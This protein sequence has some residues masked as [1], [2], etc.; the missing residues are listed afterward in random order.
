M[1]LRLTN[2]DD[3]CTEK[4]E[5]TLAD[6]NDQFK[7]PVDYEELLFVAEDDEGNFLGGL[8]AFRAWELLSIEMLASVSK[9][10]GTGSKLLHM[11]ED[12]CR[13]NG[14][15]KIKLWTMDF[16]A[17]LFYE[18]HGF[19]AFGYVSNLAGE[20]GATYMVKEVNE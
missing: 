16:Q 14:L 12:Y 6:Y 10:Q 13:Q 19:S 4:V 1:K 15:K 7:P 3:P 9:N 11:A 18:K 17:K 8:R 20:Y 5:Q 2:W